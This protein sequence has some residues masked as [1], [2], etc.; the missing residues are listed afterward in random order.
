M[1]IGTDDEGKR[2]IE[3]RGESDND[4]QKEKKKDVQHGTERA[5]FCKKQ[6]VL[7]SFSFLTPISP[8]N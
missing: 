6:T 4:Q 8:N 2:K 1:N 7:V 5:D 3:T